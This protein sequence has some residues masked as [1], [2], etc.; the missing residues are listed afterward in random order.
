MISEEGRSGVDNIYTLTSLL[1]SFIQLGQGSPV[2]PESCFFDGKQGVVTVGDCERKLTTNKPMN[3][4]EITC[5]EEIKNVAKGNRCL[6]PFVCLRE[7]EHLNAGEILV[8]SFETDK[9]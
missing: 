1:P 3:F 9:Q 6:P 4:Y 2:L 7:K 5:V 8:E